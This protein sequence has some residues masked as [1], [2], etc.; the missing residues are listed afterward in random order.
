MPVVAVLPE[1]ENPGDDVLVKATIG[2][3]PFDNH[4]H[5]FEAVGSLIHLVKDQAEQAQLLQAVIAPL[6]QDLAKAVQTVSGGAVP[7]PLVILQVHHVIS[8][9]G[10]IASGFPDAPE[11]QPETPPNWEPVYQQG[12]EAILNTLQA[13]K[14]QRIVRDAVSLQGPVSG[15]ALHLTQILES[16]RLF[17][18][19]QNYDDARYAIHPY[20]GREHG[21]RI[22][23]PGVGRIPQFPGYAGA[24]VERTSKWRV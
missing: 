23:C 15:F 20:L 9:I 14:S 22:R 21:G 5:L 6:L 13:F 4:L 17:G 8:A 10:A 16:Y 2:S 3:Q 24:Q 11:F 12:I 7:E 1:I 18:Y 19:H